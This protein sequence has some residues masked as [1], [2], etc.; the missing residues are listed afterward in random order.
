MV[1]STGLES[2]LSVKMIGNFVML[3]AVMQRK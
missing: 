1:I 3:K 2:L